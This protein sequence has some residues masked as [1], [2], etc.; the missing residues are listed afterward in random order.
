MTDIQYLWCIANNLRDICTYACILFGTFGVVVVI[1]YLLD[2]P[3]NKD[4]LKKVIWPFVFVF[5]LSLLVTILVPS[6][7]IYVQI[8]QLNKQN[9]EL[10]KQVTQM[11]YVIGKYNLE[12][13]LEEIRQ[14]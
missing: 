12:K 11:E 1:Y 8:T 6:N 5:V 4:I 2:C 3:F 13:Q 7:Y 14:R 10:H 9:L